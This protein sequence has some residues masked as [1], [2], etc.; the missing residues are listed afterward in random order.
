MT[1][2]IKCMTLCL[3]TLLTSAASVPACAGTFKVVHDFE[4][5]KDGANPLASPTWVADQLYSTTE[6][7]GTGTYGT[8][9]KLNKGGKETTLHSFSGEAD[10]GD[11]S[12]NL[13]ALNG[14]LYG[15]TSTGGANDEGTVFSITPDGKE[16]VLH[17]FVGPRDGR[18]P[19][20][21]L[22]AMNGVLYGATAAGGDASCNGG[23]GCGVVYSIT[24][25]RPK[26]DKTARGQYFRSRRRV[27]S[28]C[29]T[30]LPMARMAGRLP[31]A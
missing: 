23:S 4:A 6:S 14:L 20:S 15:T 7:G 25:L 28:T 22:V 1:I 3:F 30:A 12:S 18:F 13:A 29:Y 8:A 16:T 9:Y 10:G 24:A 11:P 26:A 2:T 17:S 21:G 5:G 31:R 19:L 27:I